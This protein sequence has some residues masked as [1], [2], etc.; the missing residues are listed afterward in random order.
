[1]TKIF[2]LLAVELA[3]LVKKDNIHLAMVVMGLVQIIVGLAIFM[4]TKFND[5]G[6][7]A[8][9][10]GFFNILAYSMVDNI[11]EDAAYEL[12]K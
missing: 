4:F 12:N 3:K 11:I 6:V 1:M 7:V 2:E 10:L 9:A 8:M 5:Y